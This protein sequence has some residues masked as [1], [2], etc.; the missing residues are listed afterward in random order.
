MLDIRVILYTYPVLLLFSVAVLHNLNIF[1]VIIANERMKKE[2]GF[3]GNSHW[4]SNNT[5]STFFL[6]TVDLK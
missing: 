2:M 3:L 4:C 6:F 1:N 5:F